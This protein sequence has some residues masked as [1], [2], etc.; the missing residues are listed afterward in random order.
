VRSTFEFIERTFQI[1]KGIGPWRERE[2]WANHIETWGDFETQ[3]RQQTVISKTIDQSLLAAI[4]HCRS[5]M[6][7]IVT[8][9][10]A[11]AAREHWRLYR[12]FESTTA[13]I[14][15]EADAERSPTVLGLLDAQGVASFRRDLQFQGAENRLAQSKIWVTFN[16][17]AF[18]LPIL[19]KLFPHLAR[20]LAHIDVKVLLAK[21]KLTGGLKQIELNLNLGRPEHVRNLD[22]RSAIALWNDWSLATNRLALQRL[23]EYNLYDTVNLK[24]LLE[25]AQ[26]K[27]AERFL[28]TL[29]P[30]RIFERGDVLY[31]VTRLVESV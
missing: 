31:D 16:G 25:W 19:D 27:L 24:W 22:G 11:I 3:A 12:H 21:L 20:P 30:T 26:W 5:S 9:S 4:E 10:S 17:G 28:W 15:L 13:F 14:D 2:L 8:L 6:L 23:V 7:D 1:V 18:D 29:E